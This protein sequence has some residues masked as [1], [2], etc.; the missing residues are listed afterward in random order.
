[1]Q[2]SGLVKVCF[3][4]PPLWQKIWIL[5]LMNSILMKVMISSYF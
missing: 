1:M 4:T 5:T 3:D 2:N